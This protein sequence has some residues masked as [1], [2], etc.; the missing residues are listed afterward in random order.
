MKGMLIKPGIVVAFAN[1][2][3]NRVITAVIIVIGRL[4]S[5]ENVGT[6]KNLHHTNVRMSASVHI[7]HVKGYDKEKATNV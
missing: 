7:L 2:G 3:Q 5:M 6:R 4:T 1:L